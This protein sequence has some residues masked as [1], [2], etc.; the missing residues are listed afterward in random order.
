MNKNT[1]YGVLLVIIVLAGLFYWYM[2][3][4]P[5]SAAIESAQEKIKPVNPN[6]LT[7]STVESIKNYDKN[8]NIPVITQGKSLG[9]TNPFQ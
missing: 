4:I 6:V 8:G 3:S 7:N 1:I 9:K 2:Q 5:S